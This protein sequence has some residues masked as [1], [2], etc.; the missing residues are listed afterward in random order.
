MNVADQDRSI[1]FYRLLGF[2]AEEEA[3]QQG[4]GL[5][6]EAHGF[7]GPIEFEGVDVSLPGT[8]D[9]LPFGGDDEATLQIR[10]WKT[11]FNAAPPYSPSVNH[12]GI[13]RI[14]FHVDYLNAAIAEMNRLGFEQLGPIGG[15]QGRVGSIAIVFFYDPDGIE[16]ELWGSLS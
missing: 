6:A 5:F 16:V 9:P 2:T 4:S 12:L 3:S 8:T 10:Q 1:E 15:G 7:E 13:D 14:A 11:P